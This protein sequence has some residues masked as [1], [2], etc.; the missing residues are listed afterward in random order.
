VVKTVSHCG[1]EQAAN[2]GG[3]T[4]VHYYY[5]DRWQ[6]VETRDGSAQ[7]TFQY[8]WGTQYVD[9]L[10]LIDANGDPTDGD[11]ANPDAEAQGESGESPADARYFVHQDRNWN[12][13]A[14]T[15]YGEGVNGAVVE[16][17]SYTP[18]GQFVVL[19]GDA[20][21]VEL[22]SVRLSSAVGN[23]FGHQ[24][25]AFDAEKGSYQNRRR[26]YAAGLGRF[27]QRDPL[28][29]PL[30]GRARHRNVVG[31]YAYQGAHPTNASDVLGLCERPLIPGGGPPPS[32]D[33]PL[34]WGSCSDLPAGGAGITCDEGGNLV[35]KLPTRSPS[36][37]GFNC[38]PTNCGTKCN[39]CNCMGQHEEQHIDDVEQHF[40]DWLSN[41]PC[42]APGEQCLGH[43]P[44][45]QV[46]ADWMEC[47]GFA[48]E[49]ACVKCA[50]D[51]PPDAPNC[52]CGKLNKKRKTYVAER[53]R[54]K[55][56][57]AGL[58]WPY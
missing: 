33:P 12:V 32:G 38:R 53:G 28:A 3:D 39:L 9:E 56:G 4:V 6:I 18:Y 14:L 20:A 8:V 58:S 30:K 54:T 7:T 2:D 5:S 22:G 21:G 34:Q 15:A 13:V 47:R 24:G 37:G 36:G 50:A 25:L 1:A 16:R 17:Y 27:A 40:S 41:N 31:L 10:V 11:D 52:C 55:C 46:L 43:G 23:V 29:Q 35:P 48:A 49:Y 45:N 42:T 19:R 57:N 51:N 26:E 44:E